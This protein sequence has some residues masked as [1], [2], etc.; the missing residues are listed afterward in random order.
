MFLSQAVNGDKR[1]YLVTSKRRFNKLSL[2]SSSFKDHF[3][4]LISI[5]KHQ[6][7][8]SLHISCFI[9]VCNL[10]CLLELMPNLKKIEL[11]QLNAIVLKPETSNIKLDLPKLIE[12]RVFNFSCLGIFNNLPT[13]LL[14]RLGLGCRKGRDFSRHH[15]LSWQPSLDERLSIESLFHHQMNLEEISSCVQLSNF[16]AMKLLKEMTAIIHNADY[17]QR[18][19]DNLKFIEVLN[20]KIDYQ[21]GNDELRPL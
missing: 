2:Y 8:R 16:K 4:Q 11:L 14:R 3:D 19:C 12:L 17:L 10:V 6:A 18:M 7:I 21:I 5:L 13:G 15:Y 20:L 9:N 1:D